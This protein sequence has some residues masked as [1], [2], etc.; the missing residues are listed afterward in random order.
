MIGILA[1]AVVIILLALV[2]TKKMINRHAPK[3]AGRLR[4]AIR[5]SRM[6]IK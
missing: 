5:K 1:G 6:S 2:V 4:M 3:E